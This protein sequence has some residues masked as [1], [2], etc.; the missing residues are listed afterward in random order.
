MDIEISAPG[1]G[2][3]EDS[4]PSSD[5]RSRIRTLTWIPLEGELRGIVQVVHGMSEHVG[6]YEGFAQV[7][8]GA[9][10]IVVGDDHVGHG[11]SV[12]GSADL[13]HMPIEGA[14]IMV[15]DVRRLCLLYRGAYP[16]LPF[17]LFGHSMG[18]FIARR[19]CEEFGSELAGA[20]LCGTGSVPLPV[21]L[22]ANALCKAVARRKGERHRSY[23]IDA[24][25]AG[26]YS[27]R[28]EGAT[29]KLDWLSVNPENVERYREDPLCGEV[30]SVGA[31]AS[32]TML[33]AEVATRDH[34][35]KVPHGLPL[36]FVSG[37]MDPVGDFGKGVLEACELYRNAGVLDCRMRLYPG[38]R[39][40][41]LNEYEHAQVEADI[42][43]WI[44]EHLPDSAQLRTPAHA[45]KHARR[46]EDA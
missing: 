43:S 38:L 3:F 8:A 35:L 5:G 30:F 23:K 1:V 7:L 17:F 36:F 14:D 25:G 37:T 46:K 18:S 28:I 45:G 12:V 22:A 33:T 34:A 29:G 40:E 44:E 41:I 6:R 4:F 39:H 10:F 24:L 20:I 21:S 2:R 27:K 15:N 16:E 42:L 32:L 11:K 26:G 13:G 19:C 31:Y 9:G